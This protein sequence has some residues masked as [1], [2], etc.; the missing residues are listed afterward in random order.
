[1]NRRLT[2]TQLKTLLRLET[3]LLGLFVVGAVAWYQ[4]EQRTQDAKEEVDRVEQHLN[5]AKDD[6]IFWEANYDS[7]SLKGEI[8]QLQLALASQDIPSHQEALSFGTAVFA[9]S[10]EQ[11]LPLSTFERTESS[12]TPD[13]EDE[14]Q[15]IH[16][17]IVARGSEESLVGV[18]GLL[19]AHPT[20]VVQT[21]KFARL[22]E[23]L[24]DWQMTLELDV[25]YVGGDA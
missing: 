5:V 17:S 24:Q 16:Y 22:T 14:R 6:L 25:F 21:L 9:Y 15:L 23:S 19:A 12:I 18:L 3:I 8:G 13:G 2:I 10:A 4:L 7:D 1:M 11:G 20:A